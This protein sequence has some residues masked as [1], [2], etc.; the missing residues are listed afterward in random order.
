M[1]FKTDRIKS[2]F[3]QLNVKNPRL[4]A[5]L[6]VL[7][8]FAILELGHE[9]TLTCILRT[10]EENDALYAA[11]PVDQRPKNTPH[12]SWLAADLRSSDFTQDQI[13]RLLALANQFKWQRTVAICHAIAG[14]VMHFHVQY[15]EL[16]A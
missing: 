14:N 2:E 16:H 10:K 7:D 13:N 5:L 15:G 9:I 12:C 1:Q 8:Q 6:I 11:T 4:H 3:D